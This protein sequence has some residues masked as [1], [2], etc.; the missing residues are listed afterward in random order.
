M[1]RPFLGSQIDHG[2]ALGTLCRSLEKRHAERGL[3]PCSLPYLNAHLN[4]SGSRSR[5][6]QMQGCSLALL[7]I[8][9]PPR[10]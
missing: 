6:V 8:W 3:N 2:P 10:A 7:A 5:H 9:R 1:R 4:G